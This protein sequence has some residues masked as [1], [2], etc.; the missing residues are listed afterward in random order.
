MIPKPYISKEKSLPP[1]KPEDKTFLDWAE[2]YV[3][4]AEGLLKIAKKLEASGR[5]S[6]P[7]SEAAEVTLMIKCYGT[8]KA[9]AERQMLRMMDEGNIPV[10][11][12]LEAGKILHP[13]MPGV[14][15]EVK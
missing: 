12:F 15:R 4:N 10:A 5:K 6:I 3:D 7:I 2:E 14:F 13:Y 9:E 8:L 11:D 1:K